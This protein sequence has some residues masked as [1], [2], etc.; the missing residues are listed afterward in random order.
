MVIIQDAIAGIE[1][2]LSVAPNST[3]TGGTLPLDLSSLPGTTVAA[4]YDP[5]TLSIIQ[6]DQL[7]Q[8]DSEAT[9]QGVVH[10]FISKAFPGNFLILTVEGE[11]RVVTHTENTVISRD[12]RRVSISEVRLGDLV[13]PATRFCAEAT[14]GGSGCGAERDLVVLSLR[15][16]GTAPV[17]GTIRGIAEGTGGGTLI[18]IS[19]NWLELVSVLVTD[20]TPVIN[21]ERISGSA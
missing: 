17:Q 15:S 11:I 18:T 16:P 10:S 21:A 6:L 3:I 4:S 9:A 5:E 19:N 20:E 2:N 14:P 1:V 13:R 8:T 7:A 12:G